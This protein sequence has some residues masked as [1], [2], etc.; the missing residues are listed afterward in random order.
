MEEPKEIENWVFKGLDQNGTAMDCL[1][2]QTFTQG[3]WTNR[4]IV[5]LKVTVKRFLLK[6]PSNILILVVLDICMAYTFIYFYFQPFSTII[7]YVVLLKT[8]Y[9]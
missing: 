8:E 7:F 3:G 5:L 4:Q 1:Q 9:I 6:Y 2:A